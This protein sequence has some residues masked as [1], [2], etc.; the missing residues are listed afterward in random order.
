MSLVVSCDIVSIFSA[1]SLR[2]RGLD[3]IGILSPKV[4]FLLTQ[5]YEKLKCQF[6]DQS[7]KGPEVCQCC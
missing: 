5:S 7:H 1:F 6:D 4:S 3:H 2:A